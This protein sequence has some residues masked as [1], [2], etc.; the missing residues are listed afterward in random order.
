TTTTPHAVESTGADTPG[1]PTTSPPQPVQS[2]ASILGS[3]VCQ[4]TFVGYR[5]S[6]SDVFTDVPS[7]PLVAP[8]EAFS[9]VGSPSRP[10]PDADTFDTTYFSFGDEVL[11]T[12]ATVQAQDVLPDCTTL[13]RL[14]RFRA[15]SHDI[16]MGAWSPPPIANGVRTF[17]FTHTYSDVRDYQ[18]RFD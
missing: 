7:S 6:L 3:E 16:A 10:A 9:F 13:C 8:C 18:A 12:D 5:L 2:P 1:A 14:V 17:V 15:S 4:N 11:A